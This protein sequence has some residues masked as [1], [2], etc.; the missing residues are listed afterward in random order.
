VQATV[1]EPP[2]SGKSSAP[3]RPPPPVL[4]AGVA[5]PTYARGRDHRRLS[6]AVTFATVFVVLAVICFALGYLFGRVALTG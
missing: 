3:F 6:G 4:F 2:P 5:A 1:A